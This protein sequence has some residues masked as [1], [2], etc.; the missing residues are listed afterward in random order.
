MSQDPQ[1]RT[2]DQGYINLT[3]PPRCV[4]EASSRTPILPEERAR[5]DFRIA[6]LFRRLDREKL[7]HPQI[8][9]SE[10][11]RKVFFKLH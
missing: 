2:P 3:P 7:L 9:R 1:V 5:V 4:S 11:D 6:G 8:L 10:A